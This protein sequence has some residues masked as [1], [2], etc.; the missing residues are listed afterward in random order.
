MPIGEDLF[1]LTPMDLA[2]IRYQQCRL[3]FVQ[4]L[5][6]Y[7]SAYPEAE[8][9]AFFIPNGILLGHR[10]TRVNPYDPNSEHRSPYWYVTYA[11]GNIGSLL[12]FMPYYLDTVGFS[13]YM[14]YP[15]RPIRYIPTDKLLNRYNHGQSLAKT[16]CAG[17]TTSAAATSAATSACGKST[18]KEAGS[19]I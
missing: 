16:S 9:Y 3:D 4:L 7:V 11:Q 17:C 8:R 18:D 1:R 13:R 15:N 14:K 10:E 12:R 5:D 19:P 6:Q 2:V